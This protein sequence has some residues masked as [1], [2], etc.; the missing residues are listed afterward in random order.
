MSLKR[1]NLRALDDRGGLLLI[2]FIPTLVVY[3]VASYGQTF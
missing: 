3:S 2:L 1:V